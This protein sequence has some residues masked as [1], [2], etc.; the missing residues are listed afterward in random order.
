M[1]FIL[2][3]SINGINSF[4]ID[5]NKYAVL[6]GGT[7]E[8]GFSVAVT[9]QHLFVAAPKEEEGRGALY[10]CERNLPGW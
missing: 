8:F 1:I 5:T 10:H 4:N 2:L 3:L 9:A 6:E 7:G